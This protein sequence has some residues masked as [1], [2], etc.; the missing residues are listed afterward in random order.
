MTATQ[1]GPTTYEGTLY[2][3]T[4]PAFTQLAFD[5]G[6]VAL[7]EAGTATLVF[8]GD[9]EGQFTY[10]LS[11]GQSQKPIFK[12][13][14]AGRQ[15]TCEYSTTRDSFLGVNLTDL[16]IASGQPGWAIAL[17]HIHPGLLMA[18]WFTYDA[19]GSPT[20]F[21]GVADDFYGDFNG[22]ILRASTA[23]GPVYGPAA[24]TYTDISDLYVGQMTDG[25]L[26]FD[27]RV[28]IIPQERTITRYVFRGKGTMCY[29]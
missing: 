18:T 22:Y 13:A 15:P 11:G 19:D 27:T 9:N 20:W 6:K 24:L 28:K 3:S 8:N 5:P 16:W 2:R 26:F 1:V 4:G 29:P 23:P 14:A 10:R 25:E 7:R 17:A 21:Y 12:F